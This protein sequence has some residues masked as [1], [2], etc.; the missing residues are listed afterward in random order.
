MARSNHLCASVAQESASATPRTK[1]AYVGLAAAQSPNAPST[2]THAAD[3]WARAQISV[4][5]SNAP[6]FT[7]PACM[8]TIAGPL[9]GGIA[10]ATMRP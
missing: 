5:G 4:V 7:F 9:M 2:C 10:L 3:A 8:Q 1:C 6:V